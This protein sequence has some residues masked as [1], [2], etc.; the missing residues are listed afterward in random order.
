VYFERVLPKLNR[1]W[2]RDGLGLLGI[3]L[4][5]L[6]GTLLIAPTVIKAY[7]NYSVDL[8]T[9]YPQN[10]PTS[11]YAIGNADSAGWALVYV[12]VSMGIGLAAGLL[13]GLLMK[14]IERP[15]C[16][17]F[18][19]AETFKGGAYGLREPLAAP[20]AGLTVSAQDLNR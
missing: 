4:V 13:V 2:V 20:E 10:S 5:S 15:T 8:P 12:G 7:Y 19:D 16:K 18:D 1:G 17:Y 11:N 3:L 6:L 14:A 9:L